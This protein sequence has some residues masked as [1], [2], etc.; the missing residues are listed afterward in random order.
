MSRLP[1]RVLGLVLAGAAIGSLVGCELIVQL[2]DALVDS[3]ADAGLNL[4]DCPICD[5]DASADAEAPDAPRD[6]ASEKP[7]EDGGAADAKPGDASVDANP[8]D[9]KP[10]DARAGD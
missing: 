5:P 10:A 4:Q 6:A 8:A 1:K 2:D 3:G 7:V 9:A